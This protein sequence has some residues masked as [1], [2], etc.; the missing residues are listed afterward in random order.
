[1]PSKQD[2]LDTLLVAL[3]R[4]HQRATYAA[5]GG[6]IGLPA[7]SVMQGRAKSTLNSWVVSKD[8]SLPTGYLTGDCHPRLTA[9]AHVIQTAA[10]LQAWLDTHS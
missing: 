1:M 10:E 9:S 2:R 8:R 7:Q 3:D 5:V 6:L 4:H